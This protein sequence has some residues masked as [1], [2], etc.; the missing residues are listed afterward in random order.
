MKFITFIIIFFSTPLMAQ[1]NNGADYGL[2]DLIN[3]AVTRN[4]KIDPVNTEK[5]MIRTQIDQVTQPAPMLE[6]MAD[7]VPV[8]FS[9]GGMIKI[10]YSQMLKLFGKLE[11]ERELRRIKLL[12]P[13]IEKAD[14][15]R[16]LIMEVKENYFKLYL[17]EQQLYFNSEMQQLMEGIIRSSEIMYSS[18]MGSQY[19]VMKANNEYQELLLEE[20]EIIT[21]RRNI[22]NNLETITNLELEDDFKTR[23]IELVL[24]LHPP[25][26]DTSYLYA[27]MIDN[28][29]VFK[30]LNFLKLENTAERNVIELE[31]KPDITL[32]SGYMYMTERKENFLMFSIMFDLPFMP[33]N[34]KR[35][36]AMLEENRIKNR[37]I[38]EVIL[39]TESYLKNDINNIVNE[40][41][42]RLE[43]IDFLKK[44]T[45]PQY[46]QTLS[47]GIIS[48][49]TASGEFMS[50][51]D[52]FRMLRM[53]DL[54]LK[55]EE[56]EYLIK[57]AE[58][59]RLIGT[60][61]FKIN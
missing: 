44:V 35:I 11:A 38:S 23:N 3:S 25:D 58:L 30:K 53:N 56:A 24:N 16:D 41:N 19:Q 17:A 60:E 7:D 51:I 28:N 59:E 27:S 9:H 1:N 2:N 61:I 39:Q 50:L 13:E 4:L 57:I 32:K 22:L 55:D 54:K 40:I 20:Y 21:N 8:N 29:P 6:L 15:Q 43:R 26:L 52:S 46:E 5:Q 34:K 14:L 48:Y 37:K 36:D 47:A 42:L 45:L 49:E 10:M 33:W 31:R 18:G 12:D